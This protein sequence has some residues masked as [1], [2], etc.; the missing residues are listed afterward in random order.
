[1]SSRPISIPR[2][3]LGS[4][5]GLLDPPQRDRILR[6]PSSV[7]SFATFDP[8]TATGC[9]DVSNGGPTE[10]FH[11]AFRQIVIETIPGGVPHW[12]AVPQANY[13]PGVVDEGTWPRLVSVCG[14]V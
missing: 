13:A 4:T 14:W 9:V 12:R 6:H 3:L 7:L 8:L 5:P 2:V 11:S 1:M 10:P